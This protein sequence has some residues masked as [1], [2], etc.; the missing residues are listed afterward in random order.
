MVDRRCRLQCFFAAHA[1][2]FAILPKAGRYHHSARGQVAPLL[3]AFF[4]PRSRMG[5]Q[6]NPGHTQCNPVV[7]VEGLIS[8]SRTIGHPRVRC[9][10]FHSIRDL[11]TQRS[12]PLPR[13]MG[14][15]GPNSP[16]A[17]ALGWLRLAQKG[18][19]LTAL[20]GS[21]SLAQSRVSRG[22]W[23]PCTHWKEGDV[24]HH[25]RPLLYPDCLPHE[26]VSVPD[27]SDCFGNAFQPSC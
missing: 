24:L 13:T 25:S 22:R 19:P 10:S 17:S 5:L 11:T 23:W 12:R 26:M 8:L 18:S 16:T 6:W 7:W 20:A 14:P 27:A 2:C 9:I 3:A 21:L 1:I 4:Q 15:H